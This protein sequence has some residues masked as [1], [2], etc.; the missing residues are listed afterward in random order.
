MTITLF[1]WGFDVNQYD[2]CISNKTVNGKQIRIVW[3]K[4]DLKISH[5]DSEVVSEYITKYKISMVKK[6]WMGKQPNLQLD[7]ENCMTTLEWY[8]TTQKT[9]R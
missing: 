6:L 5:V 7:K 4:D 3:H 1:S 8:W 2:W 9:V